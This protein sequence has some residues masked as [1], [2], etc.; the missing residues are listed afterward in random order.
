MSRECVNASQLPTRNRL[1]F[2]SLI[3]LVILWIFVHSIFCH[4]QAFMLFVLE[5]A[6][7][8]SLYTSTK[9]N[10]ANKSGRIQWNVPKM[11]RVGKQSCKIV[12]WKNIKSLMWLF[13]QSINVFVMRNKKYPYHTSV[14]EWIAWLFRTQES[15]VLAPLKRSRKLCLFHSFII[16]SISI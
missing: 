2:S 5:I 3:I 6:W 10:W 16:P 7:Y 13:S 14:A 4:I 15:R 9:K 11:S 12:A 1:Y 8:I